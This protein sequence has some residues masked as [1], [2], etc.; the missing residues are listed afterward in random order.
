MTY[1]MLYIFNVYNLMSLEM[2]FLTEKTITT[3]YTI[4]VFI[5]SK[6]KLLECPPALARF[7]TRSVLRHGPCSTTNQSAA[8]SVTD[9]M[10]GDAC[11][12]Q[13]SR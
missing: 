9:G 11:R 6:R 2:S 13:R 4:N 10:A 1:R 7:W 8:F 5:T 12:S 3:I